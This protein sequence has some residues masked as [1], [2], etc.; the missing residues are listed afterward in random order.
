MPISMRCECG[1][2]LQ[3]KD[4]FAGRRTQ[5]PD[6][7]RELVIPGQAA[8][9][10]YQAGPVFEPGP[11]KAP[12]GFEAKTSGKAITSLVL[13]LVSPFTCFIT[14][15]PGIV[16][17][18]LGLTE[19]NKSDG[20][21]KGQ[22]LAIAGIVVSSLGMLL[23]LPAILLALLLPAVQSARE[24]A[25]RVQCSN[26]LKQIGLAMHNFESTR[27]AFPG[28]AI[29]D[30]DG[31]PLL[32]WRVAILP[33]LEESSLY[34]EFHLNEAW[35]SPHN[36]ALLARMPRTYACPSSSPPEEVAQGL[37]H[38]QAFA[39]PGT[40]MDPS[41]IQRDPDGMTKGVRLAT[42]ADGTSNTILVIEAANPVEWTKPDDLPYV[43]NGPP[44]VVGAKHAGG[45]NALFT[46]GSVRFLKNTIAGQVMNA[47]ITRAGGEVVGPDF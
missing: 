41:V 33:Y 20:R 19:A 31:K 14:A 38:Y 47:L 22:G 10:P 44:P 9:N 30:A 32:S 24:A 1:K 12:P 18:V 39:G 16:F 43:P 13:G 34:Q 26:N 11:A 2:E 42:V 46:D 6:C 21:I 17:G 15:I 37:T 3:A 45:E 28:Q 8:A 5:C 7:G 35:D 29:T 40:M 4:E 36:K 27:N 23:I 25:R